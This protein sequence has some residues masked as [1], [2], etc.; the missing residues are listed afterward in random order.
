MNLL[1]CEHCVTSKRHK[2]K[3][4]KSYTK[5]KCILDLVDSDIWESLDMPLGGASCLVT[6]I[7]DY[8]KR[9]WVYLDKKKLDVFPMFKEFKVRVKLESEKKIKCLRINNG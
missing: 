3:F 7:D 9:C 4:S 1:F 5:T 2:L 8:S 6:F